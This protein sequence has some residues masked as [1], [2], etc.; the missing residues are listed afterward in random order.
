VDD[1]QAGLKGFTKKVKPVFLATTI[2]R[3]LFDLE[4]IY[5]LSSKKNNFKIEGIPIT[6]RPGITFSHMNKKI[7][8][9][10][11]RNFLKIWW[12]S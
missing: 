9:Q 8:L 2:N 7:L 6:L 3:Y 10:E 4:F 1:T 5:L 11:A 12:R